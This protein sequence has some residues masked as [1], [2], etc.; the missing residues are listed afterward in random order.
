MIFLMKSKV[1]LE[2]VIFQYTRWNTLRRAAALVDV[3]VSKLT[4]AAAS[5]HASEMSSYGYN[6][7]WSFRPGDQQETKSKFRIS[8]GSRLKQSH[9]YL[10][11]I[12][13]GRYQ[14]HKGLIQR[15][16]HGGG[17]KPVPR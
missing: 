6:C 2:L 14:W 9:A 15:E 16:R 3:W 12:D 5:C 10:F 7:Y 1:E 11:C 8:D 13:F 4:L 17:S